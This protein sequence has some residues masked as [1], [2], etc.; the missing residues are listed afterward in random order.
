MST[1]PVTASTLSETE[2]GNFIKEKYNFNENSE[3]K[4][5]RT[6]V[7]HTYFLSD[8][9]TK[10]VVRVYCHQWRT[11]IEIEQELELLKLLQRHNLSIS[12]PVPDTNGDYIQEINAPEGLRYAVV[13]SFAEGEKMRFMTNETCFAIGSLFG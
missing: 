5:F 11:K 9:E 4:L 2:L 13:F 3:C 1:F 8:I 12:F 10:I 7:N 6:G